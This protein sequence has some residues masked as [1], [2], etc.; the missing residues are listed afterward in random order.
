MEISLSTSFHASAAHRHDDVEE[1]FNPQFVSE[2]LKYL[3]CEQLIMQF[4]DDLSPVALTGDEGFLYII[5][6]MRG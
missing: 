6:P 4:S 1:S 5:M 2:P 3:D